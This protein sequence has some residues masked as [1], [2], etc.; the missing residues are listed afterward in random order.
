MIFGEKVQFHMWLNTFTAFEFA[1]K[2]PKK[3]KKKN[4]KK[5]V[6]HCTEW[7]HFGHNFF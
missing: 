4:L 7:L 3:S 5:S 1:P 6:K 2:T